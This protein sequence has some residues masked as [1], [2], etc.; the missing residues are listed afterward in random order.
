MF[1]PYYAAS[2]EAESTIF[3]TSATKDGVQEKAIL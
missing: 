2:M 1:V 3:W